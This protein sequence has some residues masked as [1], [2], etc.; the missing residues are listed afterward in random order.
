MHDLPCPLY[1]LKRGFCCGQERPSVWH[2]RGDE[3]AT[4]TR[5]TWADEIVRTDHEALVRQRDENPRIGGMPRQEAGI[6]RR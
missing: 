4:P 5:V 2:N 6:R 3:V 1:I